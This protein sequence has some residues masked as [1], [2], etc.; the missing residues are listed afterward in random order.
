MKF[1]D[2]FKQDFNGVVEQ[3]LTFLFDVEF[4]FSPQ[5]HRNNGISKKQKMLVQF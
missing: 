3:L 5:N 1:I 4:I 2:W